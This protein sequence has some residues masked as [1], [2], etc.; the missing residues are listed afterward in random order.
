MITRIIVKIDDGVDD[1]HD[2]DEH[3]Y[4]GSG[5]VHHEIVVS[6]QD[7]ACVGDPGSKLLTLPE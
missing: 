1:N 4:E 5:E 7:G 2:G 3:C 6:S